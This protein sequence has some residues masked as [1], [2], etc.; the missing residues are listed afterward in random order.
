[1]LR[2]RAA[3]A[4][5]HD[6]N[7]LVKPQL[8]QFLWFW[9]VLGIVVLGGFESWRTDQIRYRRDEPISRAKYPA[10]FRKTAVAWMLITLVAI[11]VAIYATYT[12]WR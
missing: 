4:T 10:L 1:M 2:S 7:S 8:P 3:R 6:G 12:G 9:F 11:I 5:A